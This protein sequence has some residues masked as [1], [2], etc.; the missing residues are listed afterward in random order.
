M[1]AR[2]SSSAVPQT[3]SLP[4]HA[5]TTAEV[6][7]AA[8]FAIAGAALASA[9]Q[10]PAGSLP[11]AIASSHFASAFALDC[12]KIALALMMP[13]LHFSASAWAVA[14]PTTTASE[15]A[16][17]ASAVLRAN[18][19]NMPPSSTQLPPAPACAVFPAGEFA[20]ICRCGSVGVKLQVGETGQTFDFD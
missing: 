14:A 7:L 16:T 10:S 8:A 15:T 11:L 4:P 13:A 17:T 6:S 9:W 1:L 2:V 5:L 20:S 3:L 19:P 18:E 12:T